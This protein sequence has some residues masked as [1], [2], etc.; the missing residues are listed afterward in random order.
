M[1][2]VAAHYVYWRQLSR[3]HYIEL[4]D[5]ARFAGVYPL[6]IEI[7][8]TEFYDGTLFPLPENISITYPDF[9]VN[10]N[11]WLKLISTIE[12]GTPVRIYRLS[13]ASL[14]ASELGADYGCGN[15]HIERL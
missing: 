1:R 2:R 13:G 12:P 11:T 10:R 8:G 5:E 6:E 3:L 7:A 9:L 4:D 15:G 14:S